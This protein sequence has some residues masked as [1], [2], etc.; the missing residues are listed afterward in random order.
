M[1]LNFF[2]DENL[3]IGK[4]LIDAALAQD[5]SKYIRNFCDVR[6]EAPDPGDRSAVTRHNRRVLAYRALLF[7]AGLNPPASLRPSTR[8]LF[9]QALRSALSSGAGK[10]PAE[11]ASCATMLAK[12]TPSWAELAQAFEI[13]RNFIVDSTSGWSNFNNTYVQSSSS[14]SWADDEFGKILEMFA[15]KN[16]SRQIG[17]VKAQH[18]PDTSTDYAE[19]IYDEL[20]AGK[21]ERI[22]NYR[23]ARS[24]RLYQR[25]DRR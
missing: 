8:S 17:R 25:T 18:T 16:G 21:L 1:K 5:S 12:S 6:F 20:A 2:V 22:V 13:L 10:D 23:D 19:D 24:Q 11:Y 3:E 7:K 4:S 9:N 15:F 14:G